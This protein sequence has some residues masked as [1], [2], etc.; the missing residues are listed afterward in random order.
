MRLAHRCFHRAV[1]QP[2]ISIQARGRS[3][4]LRSAAKSPAEVTSNHESM[5]IYKLKEGCLLFLYLGDITRFDGDAIV[6]AANERMLGGGGVDGGNMGRRGRGV[7]PP[8]RSFEVER[9]AVQADPDLLILTLSHSHPPSRRSRVGPR[10]SP[11]SD[12]PAQCPLPNG[13]GSD[14]EV[15]T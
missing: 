6:N 7:Y 8:C 12:R 11:G 14:H 5:D 4:S 3:T 9:R 15:W 13:G 10:M 1:N 2:I